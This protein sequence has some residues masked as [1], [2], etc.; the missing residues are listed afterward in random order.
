[1][2]ADDI[3]LVTVN[4]LGEAQKMLLELEQASKKVNLRINYGH[5]KYGCE[6]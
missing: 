5:D 1:M 4:C 2:F 6:Y 3:I